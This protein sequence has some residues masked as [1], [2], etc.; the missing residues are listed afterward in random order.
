MAGQGGRG[1]ADHDGW[2]IIAL[3]AAVALIGPTN[4]NLSRYNG[5]YR[6]A[7][8]VPLALVLLVTVLRVGQGRGIEFIYFQF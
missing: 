7:L 6:S 1:L 4:L 3:A 5:L 8:A 2:P